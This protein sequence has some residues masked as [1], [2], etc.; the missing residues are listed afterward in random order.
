MLL[1][2]GLLFFAEGIANTGKFS[3]K[4]LFG[5]II[6]EGDMLRTDSGDPEEQITEIR[7]YDL[8]GQTYLVYSEIGC[9]ESAC[10]SDLSHLERGGYYVVVFT[11]TDSFS[12]SIQLD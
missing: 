2:F 8:P 6:V 3:Y 4:Q 12:D 7:I 11:K 1:V 10:I 9:F 5:I